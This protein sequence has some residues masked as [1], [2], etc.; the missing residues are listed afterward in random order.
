MCSLAADLAR[1]GHQQRHF[2]AVMRR[3]DARYRARGVV[4][5]DSRGVAQRVSDFLLAVHFV[6]AKAWCFSAMGQ[7][8]D[9]RETKLN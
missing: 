8:R 6:I 4:V 1:Y 7:E 2:R 5:S 3:A 9:V